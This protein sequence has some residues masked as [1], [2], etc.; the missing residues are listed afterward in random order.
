MVKREIIGIISALALIGIL[1]LLFVPLPG[2]AVNLTVAQTFSQALWE[3][4]SL[5]VFLQVLIILV[6]T[7]GILSL[8]KEKP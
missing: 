7:F 2:P 8:V 3:F 1:V 6:G 5:D 4:R